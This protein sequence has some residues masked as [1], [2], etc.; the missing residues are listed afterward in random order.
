M[1]WNTDIL[2]WDADIVVWDI[3]IMELQTLAVWVP[4]F[5]WTMF[6]VFWTWA[7]SWDG[8]ASRLPRDSNVALVRG[9]RFDC[10]HLCRD[11]AVVYC[12]C[13]CSSVMVMPWISAVDRQWREL[14]C[15]TFQV[16]TAAQT[17]G[18]S[19]PVWR[20]G[21]RW[22]VVSPRSMSESALPVA[23]HLRT[24]P[25]PFRVS[26]L[27]T[28]TYQELVHSRQINVLEFIGNYSATLSNMKLV[29][30]PLMGGLFGRRAADR[31]GPFS[32]Y[33]PTHQRPVYQL[34]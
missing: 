21:R 8:R 17:C 20:R 28:V 18:V 7:S 10:G 24:S 5:C 13:V 22:R 33:Q 12:G 31:P 3:D 29:H 16:C 11:V 14:P 30:W 26:D 1:V 27:M 9:Q 4:I 2:V 6:T 15:S 32:L 19:L 34:P 23:C 25:L